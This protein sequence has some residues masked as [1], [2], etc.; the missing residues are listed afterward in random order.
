MAET[1]V[2][3]SMKAA[4]I[5]D[6]G[7]PEVL[8]VRDVPVP[9]RPRGKVLIKVVAA[10][11]NPI[12]YKD[13]SGTSFPCTQP[14]NKIPGGDVAG[15][16]V[17]ADASAS[18]HGFKVGDRVFGL[19]PT[20]QPWFKSGTCAEYVC[21]NPGHLAHIPEGVSF[22]EAAATP[23]VALTALQ[24]LNATK[25]T[26]KDRILI[27]AG[28]GG[29]GHVAL[30]LAHIR[31]AQVSATCGTPN[32]DFVKGLGADEVIDYKKEQFDVIHRDTP[33]DVIV[34][35]LGGEYERRSLAI[36]KKGG[37]YAHIAM[38]YLGFIEHTAKW[39]GVLNFPREI[40][41]VSGR[42]LK[43]MFLRQKYSL[44]VVQPSG[45]GMKEIAELLRKR[46]LKVMVS[47]V[48]PLDKVRDAHAFLEEGHPRGKVVVRISNDNDTAAPSQS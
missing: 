22:E 30:Q 29:V 35:P 10:S 3:A 45:A 31:G 2:P 8:E 43:H 39:G 1:S 28:S 4:L 11:V 9:S 24:A 17:A 21:A 40:I 7:G 34:D 41:Q 27:Q 46:E 33:F 37:R 20:F 36:L 32:V 19:L 6:F 42:V 15:I 23:L 25:A 26:A 48:F 44:I 12:D 38:P 14:K 18:K 13:R 16:I 47:R 5:T